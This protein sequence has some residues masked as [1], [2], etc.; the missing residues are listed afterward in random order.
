MLKRIA[1]V[2]VVML[3]ALSLTGCVSAGAG[4]KSYVDSTD[5]YEFLYPNGWLPVKVSSG[6]DVVF[7]DLIETSE[8]VSVVISP[9]SEGK[10]LAELG[11]PGEVGYKLAKSAIAPPDSGRKAELVNA[12]SREKSAKT[13]YVLE[14]AV[15]LPNQQERHNLA[16]V[17]VSRGKLLTFNVSTPEKRWPK[18]QKVFKQ[19]VNSFSVE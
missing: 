10:T 13:Y 8:N 3:V 18:V 16:S 6:P 19:V 4:L 9:V 5:G 17:A 1:A 14:Y 15:K 7:H 11:T 12:E 2:L